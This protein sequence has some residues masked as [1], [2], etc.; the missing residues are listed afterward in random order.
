[1]FKKYAS[2]DGAYIP[3]TTR[4]FGICPDNYSSR[5]PQILEMVAIAKADFPGLQ[6]QDIHTVAYDGDR[7][8]RQTG[9]E[10]SRPSDAPI[11]SGYVVMPL[12]YV[13]AGN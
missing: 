1:M 5:I 6:D 2:P 11:P 9:I 7:W 13:F 10:F 12:E 3:N 4:I 8:K